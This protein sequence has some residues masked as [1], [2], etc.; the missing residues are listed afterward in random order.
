M[1]QILEMFPAV[2]WYYLLPRTLQIQLVESLFAH[3]PLIRIYKLWS[4]APT[5]RSL[6]VSKRNLKS[7]VT[8]NYGKDRVILNPTFR[9]LALHYGLA[10]VPARLSD[11]R[12]KDKVENSVDAISSRILAR[13]RTRVFSDIALDLILSR[14]TSPAPPGTA[15]NPPDIADVSCRAGRSITHTALMHLA[16]GAWIRNA[17]DLVILGATGSGKTFLACALAAN[18]CRQ[19]RSILYRRVSDLTEEIACAR[20]NGKGYQLMRRLERL[21]LLV[22]DDRGLVSMCA[23]GRRAILE[24]VEKRHRR[25]ATIIVSQ[26]PPESWYQIIG[27]PT[28]ADAVCDRILNNAYRIDL[29]GDSMRRAQA[30]ASLEA[31][32]ARPKEETGMT[33][34]MLERKARLRRSETL[35]KGT[36]GFP[37]ERHLG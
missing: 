3:A 17:T 12:G 35:H 8:F 19:Q 2:A 27:E 13:L 1:P 32:T 21:N 10:A 4:N 25:A 29:A 28:I 26:V 36:A 9:E 22:L 37:A 23:A 34:G 7:G 16:A 31:D 30:P 33:P 5:Q 20:E 6:R 18:A 14:R 15:A 11:P 24:V